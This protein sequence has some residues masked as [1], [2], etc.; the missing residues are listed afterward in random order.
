MIDLRI[1]ASLGL[2]QV[3]KFKLLRL[4]I[5]ERL[6]ADKVE[7]FCVRLNARDFLV[8]TNGHLDLVDSEHIVHDGVSSDEDV[9][10]DRDWRHKHKL[11][12]WVRLSRVKEV[13]LESCIIDFC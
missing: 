2:E 11:Q 12:R 7:H 8:S 4:T 3:E 10:E 9:F 5:C 1:G 6:I 13:E